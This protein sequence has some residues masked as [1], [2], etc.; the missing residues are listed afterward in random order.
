MLLFPDF[1]RP[2][3]PEDWVRFKFQF[4]AYFYSKFAKQKII[5]TPIDAFS[6]QKALP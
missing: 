3:Q 6:L 1:K 2:E 4:V 5:G